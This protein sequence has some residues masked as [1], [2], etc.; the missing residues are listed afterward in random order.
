MEDKVNIKIRHFYLKFYK[1]RV[2]GQ[3]Y[4]PTSEF[5]NGKEWQSKLYGKD[6]AT[7]AESRMHHAQGWYFLQIFVQIAFKL[8]IFFPFQVTISPTE[9]MIFGGKSTYYPL[10]VEKFN[11]E[12]N[13]WTALAPLTSDQTGQD[14][15]R[16]YSNYFSF[17]YFM[18]V[19]Y[20]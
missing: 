6:F 16:S 18:S 20:F 19:V 15:K 12:T 13:S 8:K 5:Y 11:F 1:K 7:V 10:E 14:A 2:Q 9:V 17:T 4:L 3:P